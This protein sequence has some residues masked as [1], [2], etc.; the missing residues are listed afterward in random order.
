MAGQEHTSSVGRTD[1]GGI[2][3]GLWLPLFDELADPVVV[4]DLAAEAE[5]A[6]WH[7]VFVWD[8][9]RWG[10]GRRS[11]GGGLV[12]GVG[13]GS[14]RFGYSPSTRSHGTRSAGW[15]A[16]GRRPPPDPWTSILTR[17]RQMSGGR[18]R[19]TLRC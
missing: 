15:S 19:P 13:L 9:L 18:R 8:H 2:R 5:E 7:G 17:R 11:G 14:D 6:R 12:L 1:R 4:A 16:T 3:S 10:G